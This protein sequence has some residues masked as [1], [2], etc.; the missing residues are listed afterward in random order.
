[1]TYPCNRC[2]RCFIKH[3]GN[4]KILKCWFCDAICLGF[5]GICKNCENE[6]IIQK[7]VSSAHNHLKTCPFS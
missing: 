3:T 5:V 6:K 7:I 1:M 4:C 2:N